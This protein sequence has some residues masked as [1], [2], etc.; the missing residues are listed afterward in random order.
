MKVGDLVRGTKEGS[1]EGSVG[2]IIG[3]DVDHDPIVSWT[4]PYAHEGSNVFSPGC[5]EYRSQ[6][7]VVNEAR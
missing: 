5:G 2:I 3:F 6:V 1:W 7:E 4:G